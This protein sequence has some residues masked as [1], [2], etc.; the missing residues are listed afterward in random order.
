MSKHLILES[1]GQR[2]LSPRGGGIFV[3]P[4]IDE[5]YWIYRVRLTDRQALIAF[6][7]FGLVGIG[8]AVEDDDWNTNLPSDCDAVE[9]FEHIECNKGDDSISD[10]DCLAAIRM[11]QDAV[12]SGCD[13]C[14]GPGPLV[15]HVHGMR[16]CQSCFPE[17]DAFA[18]AA[19][20]A[21]AAA[22]TGGV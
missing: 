22:E 12:S 16:V 21:R 19:E 10:E 20:S 15:P 7:K 17:P 9:I 3:T 4:P 5:S 14:H 2:D 1:K 11:L 13:N 6:P 18:S 8:F